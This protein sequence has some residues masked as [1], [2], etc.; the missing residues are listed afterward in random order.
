MAPATKA[1]TQRT[2]PATVVV[3]VSELLLAKNTKKARVR[4][5]LPDG[6]ATAQQTPAI[7]MQ[8]GNRSVRVDWSISI[9]IQPG[10]SAWTAL[11]AALERR[12]QPEAAAIRFTVL[13]ESTGVIGDAVVDLS[14][15]AEYGRYDKES[16]KMTLNVVDKRGVAHGQLIAHV[17]ALEAVR[18][19]LK[20]APSPPPPLPLS[21]EPKVKKAFETF[22]KNGDGSIDADELREALKY[23]GLNASAAQ[24]REVLERY[25]T[26]FRD[27]KLDLGEFARLVQDLNSF[28]GG[29]GAL[30]GGMGTADERVR[31]AFSR[32]DVDGNGRLD[33]VEIK[34][35]LATLG[36][37]AS[38]SEAVAVLQKYDTDRSGGVELA[39]FAQLVNDL[40]AFQGGGSKDIPHEVRKAFA[41][42]D[43]DGN[44]RIDAFELRTALHHLGVEASS[45]Q[46][47][48]VL[49]KYDVDRSR[50]LDI[51]E[52][53]KLVM[54]V[55]EFQ[56]GVSRDK[57]LEQ[58]KLPQVVMLLNRHR[59]ALDELF[60]AFARRDE[61]FVLASGLAHTDEELRAAFA[62]F[63]PE[64]SGAIDAKALGGALARLGVPTNGEQAERV[65]ARYQPGSGSSMVGLSEFRALV[66][67]LRRFATAA[68]PE[69]SAAKGG[70]V[71]SEATSRML[72]VEE[73]LSMCHGFR[74]V[75]DRLR[76][77]EVKT[78]V[79]EMQPSSTAVGQLQ[80]FKRLFFDE[81][82]LRMAHVVASRTGGVQSA[83]PH[84][85]LEELFQFMRLD[86]VAAMRMLMRTHMLIEACTSGELAQ[87]RRLLGEGAPVDGRGYDG[88]SPL[89]RAAAYGHEEAVEALIHAGASLPL[90]TPD[91]FSALHWACEYGHPGV[92]R[93]LLKARAPVADVSDETLW[94]PLHRAALDGHLA[95]VKLLLSE[96][97]PVAVRD[98]EGDTPLHDAAR[99]GHLAVGQGT[100]GRVAR[101]HAPR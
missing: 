59:T 24:T 96:G 77:E 46:A 10:G 74:L 19:V 63:D 14:R 33:A 80:P 21:I 34:Q 38:S 44:G 35:A 26:G 55:R 28:T 42:F 20:G 88:W 32:F 47:L 13:D 62:T 27:G 43:S 85:R 90:K 7:D 60:S 57:V 36:M 101:G 76:E 54:D 68:A 56:K 78:A 40:I 3:G 50:E 81:V 4:V 45:A 25:D 72:G 75:P 12:A 98:R 65:L 22:D 8:G 69:P 52:F 99:N 66:A 58:L 71:L 64:G 83:E 84:V 82:L 67:D 18:L 11:E 87:V 100:G 23:L 16:P 95:V 70:A 61:T 6:L 15:L 9:P 17:Q 31:V 92:V 94:T 86:T 30:D 1:T 49:K 53:A 39:E 73:L 2:E 29:G 91:G 93:L 41:H 48:A 37:V 97:A 79:R 5:E 51:D 89:H